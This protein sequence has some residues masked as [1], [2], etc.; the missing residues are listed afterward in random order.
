METQ[1][2]FK[3]MKKEKKRIKEGASKVG[4]GI[5]PFVRSIVLKYLNEEEKNGNTG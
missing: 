4:L 2:Q 5:S 3:L 1:I